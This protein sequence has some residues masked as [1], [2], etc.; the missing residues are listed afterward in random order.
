MENA[1]LINSLEFTTE[2]FLINEEDKIT[3]FRYNEAETTPFHHANRTV[4]NYEAKA[5]RSDNKLGVYGFTEEQIKLGRCNYFLNAFSDSVSLKAPVRFL[6]LEVDKN[7]VF[8]RDDMEV[9][10]TEANF[11][12]ELSLSELSE[13]FPQYAEMMKAYEQISNDFKIDEHYFR[14]KLQESYRSMSILTSIE[15]IIEPVHGIAHGIRVERNGNMICQML[16]ID[17][18][19]IRPFAYLHDFCRVNDGTDPEHGLRA[20]NHIETHYEFV[21]FHFGL[22][23]V[24]MKLLKYACEHHTSMLKS[25]FEIVNAC[26]DADRLDLKRTGT[27]LDPNY[28]ATGIGALFAVSSRN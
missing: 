23:D 22:S 28:M 5:V 10:F 4:W 9:V 14:T 25:D 18:R 20:S 1:L 2:P 11:I 13:L 26:F 8:Y 27:V 24:E 21:K 3:V 17:N 16:G 19:V 12:Q 6:K 15:K 7:K